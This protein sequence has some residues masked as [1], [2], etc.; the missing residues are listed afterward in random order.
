MRKAYAFG[1]VLA[2]LLLSGCTG[3]EEQKPY[4]ASA[5]LMDTVVNIKTYGESSQAPEQALD[6]IK[7]LDS[8][9]NR[10]DINSDTSRVSA[11][12]GEKPVQVD[13]LT[14]DLLEEAVSYGALTEGALDITIGPLVDLWDIPD[15]DNR[16]IPRREEINEKLKLVNYR[17]IIL[18]RERSTVYLPY[19]GSSLDLGSVAKGFATRRVAEILR[20]KGVRSALISL[21][22]NIYAIGSKPD[23]EPWQI[24]IQ[25]PFDQNQSI[26]TFNIKDRAVDTAGGYYRFKEINGEKFSHIIDPSTG[27]PASEIVSVTV[28]T[29]DPLKADALSTASY[30]LGEEKG[31]ALLES[32]QGV[33]GFM[34]TKSGKVITTSNLMVEVPSFKLRA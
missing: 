1:L 27:L 33:S 11:M 21:G 29:G 15:P 10:Y 25:D 6:F 28:I 24:A 16:R 9:L 22:G 7:R 31:I 17:Q 12:A 23:G 14:L 3:K 8:L 13:D 18:D 5:L 19:K 34:V 20:G 2:F 4:Q 30:V 26:A 32:F